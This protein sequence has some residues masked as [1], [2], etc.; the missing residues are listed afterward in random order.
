MSKVLILLLVTLATGACSYKKA[1]D[2]P[3]P[4]P[5][6]ISPPEALHAR[7]GHISVFSDKEADEARVYFIS[8]VEQPPEAS[9]ARANDQ[10]INF[11]DS[12]GLPED[13]KQL[14][15]IGIETKINYGCD[16][17]ELAAFPGKIVATPKSGDVRAGVVCIGRNARLGHVTHIFADVLILKNAQLTMT[18][19]LNLFGLKLQLKGANTFYSAVPECGISAPDLS[20]ETGQLEATGNLTFKTQIRNWE[21]KKC[22]NQY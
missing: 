11:Y 8:E 15:D 3:D 17:V 1:P 16:E 10:I 6:P 21:F 5:P 9:A 2:T 18:A 7:P 14:G 12:G 13:L 19:D 20:I 4:V 22:K